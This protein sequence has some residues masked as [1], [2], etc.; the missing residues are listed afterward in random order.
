MNW[1]KLFGHKWNFYKEDIEH[2]IETINNTHQSWSVN[3]NGLTNSSNSHMSVPEFTIMI[4]TEFRICERCYHK[5][6]RQHLTSKENVDWKDYELSKEQLRDMKLK[7]L[8][9]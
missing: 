7:S 9:I 1:C 4:N 3:Y 5:Q 2:K 6:Q 8:G